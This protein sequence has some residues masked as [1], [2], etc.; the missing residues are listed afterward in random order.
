MIY[1][2]NL[3]DPP[4]VNVGVRSLEHDFFTSNLGN[5]PYRVGLLWYEKEYT[6]SCPC[7][8]SPFRSESRS[9]GLP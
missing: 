9:L 5:Q 7:R 8:N 3:A 2:G 1:G 4:T 6:N